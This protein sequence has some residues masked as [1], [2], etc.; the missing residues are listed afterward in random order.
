MFYLLDDENDLLAQKYD[1]HEQVANMDLWT[2][3]KPLT[4]YKVPGKRCPRCNWRF[5]LMYRWGPERKAR[6]YSSRYPDMILG[7]GSGLIF[8]EKVKEIIIAND[9]H[10]ILSFEK[11]EIIGKN[12][13]PFHY[14]DTFVSF[15]ESKIDWKHSKI[16]KKDVRLYNDCELCGQFIK[17]AKKI[18]L[19]EDSYKSIDIFNLYSMPYRFIVSQKFYD[20]CKT[21]GLKNIR[22]IPMDHYSF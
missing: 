21:E 15:V 14:Y 1:S 18:C 12:I 19:N 22:F 7:Q 3:I 5:D 10:G 13:P 20:A 4:P 17:H 11:I 9:L 2:D 8:S 6:L 16:K